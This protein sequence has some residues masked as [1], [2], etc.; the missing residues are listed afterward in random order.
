MLTFSALLYL[1]LKSNKNSNWQWMWQH[2]KM[3][4]VIIFNSAIT[5]C[6]LSKTVCQFRLHSPIIRSVWSFLW[7]NISF[8]IREEKLQ[9]SIMYKHK[10]PSVF[11]GFQIISPI[12]I[13]VAL[14]ISN[15]LYWLTWANERLVLEEKCSTLH[16]KMTRSG[17][18]I[19]R[20]WRQPLFI[21]LHWNLCLEHSRTLL[22][23]ILLTHLACK[24]TH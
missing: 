13:R 4:Y 21:E 11:T 24:Q 5:Q 10:R 1:K 7:M 20:K 15:I 23:T 14:L 12:K 3:K 17:E 16:N 2:S 19:S 8:A 18:E 9:N 22:Q 6:S